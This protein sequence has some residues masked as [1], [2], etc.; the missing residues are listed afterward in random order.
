MRSIICTKIF[1]TINI[2]RGRYSGACC[3][4]VAAYVVVQQCETGT[5]K[6]LWPLKATAGVSAGH[7]TF[8]AKFDMLESNAF[9][10]AVR[11]ECGSGIED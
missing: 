10:C 8:A 1:F 7:G 6:L 9:T 5:G 4:F 11:V 3:L 2:V